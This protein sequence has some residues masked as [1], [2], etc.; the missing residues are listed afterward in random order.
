MCQNCFTALDAAAVNSVLAVAAA[1]TGYG[2]VKEKLGLSPLARERRYLATAAMMQELG[3]DV[4]TVLG[5]PP[6]PEGAPESEVLP[7]VAVAGSGEAITP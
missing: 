1:S 2:F 6:G 5:A 7:Q 3:L 4:A